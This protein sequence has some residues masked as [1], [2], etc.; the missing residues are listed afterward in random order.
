MTL[1]NSRE[2]IPNDYKH[3]EDLCIGNEPPDL[4][5]STSNAIIHCLHSTGNSVCVCVCV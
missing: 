5:L 4:I 1:F 2:G 3:E